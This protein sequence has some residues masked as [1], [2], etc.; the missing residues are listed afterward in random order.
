MKK[1]DT[2]TLKEKDKGLL[3]MI[4]HLPSTLEEHYGEIGPCATTQ[5]ALAET[6]HLFHSQIRNHQKTTLHNISILM[7]PGNATQHS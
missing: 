2:E 4:N 5:P 3:S 6:S 7:A 1:Y